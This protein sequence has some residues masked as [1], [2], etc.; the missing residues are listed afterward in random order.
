VALARKDGAVVASDTVPALSTD[1]KKYEVEI[2]TGKTGT[3]KDNVFTLTTTRP[4][5]LWLQA[6]SLFPPTF[7]DRPNGNRRDLMAMLTDMKPTFLRFPGG[8]YLEGDT[9]A[10]RF[11]WKKTIGDTAQR[12]G[13]R[14]SW[15]YWSTDGMGLPEFLRWCEELKMEPVLGVFAGYSL[16]G[17]RRSSPEDLA[18]FVQDA[19]DEIEYIT[20]DA[21]TTWGARRAQDGHPAPFKLRYVEIG[22]EDEFDSSHSYDQRF[23]IFYKAIK[24]KYPQLQ[25]MSTVRAAATPSQRPDLV[26]E[27]IYAWGEAQM[28]EHLNDYDE[29]PRNEPKVMIGEWATQQGW[30]MPNM[31]AAIADA[32]FLTSLE[33]NADHVVMSAYAPLFANMSHVDGHSRDKSMQWTGDLIGYDALGAFGT[34]SYY[35]QKMFSATRGDVVLES[36]GDGMPQWKVNDKDRPALYW[37]ATRREKDGRMQLKLASRAA[38]PQSVR[39]SLSGVKHVAPNGTLT[40]LTS[41]DPDAGNTLD[42]PQRIVPVARSIRNLARDFTIVVPAYSVSVLEIDAR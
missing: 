14:S 8:N 3:S 10:Q 6:V 30:L 17:E 13:H 15:N 11:D 36:S 42:A 22:N 24:T 28:Y 21:S 20:G 23:A 19:L 9:I 25:I 40:V 16:L 27:H 12:P 38:T 33:R 32:A 31:K 35:V 41:A 4:G 39:V 34:P 2:V 18:P 5:K 37:V 26:D 29:R 1:W 7:K